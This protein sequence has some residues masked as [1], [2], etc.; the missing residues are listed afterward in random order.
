MLTEEQIKLADLFIK[1]ISTIDYEKDENYV[2]YFERTNQATQSQIIEIRKL[3]SD[4]GLITKLYKSDFTVKLSINGQKALTIGVKEYFKE[5]EKA[6]IIDSTLK[7]ATIDNYKS[8]K[9][10]SK[11]AI[12]F[13]FV[14]P[15]LIAVFDKYV[16]NPERESNYKRSDRQ[17]IVDSI[18][19]QLLT[20][21]VFIE[22]TKDFIKHDTVFLNELKE[23]ITK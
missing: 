7:S 23:K 18:V 11:Y 1:H 21:S 17:E 5:I 14:V 6:E 22:K 2:L 3:L 9:K 4:N 20:D 10:L 13:S 12:I 19:S 8:T 15:I 16:Y